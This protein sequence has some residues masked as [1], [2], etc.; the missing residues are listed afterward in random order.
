MGVELQL[1]ATTDVRDE[2]S[3]LLLVVHFLF[4]DVTIRLETGKLLNSVCF[5]CKC[6]SNMSLLENVAENSG[7][8][9]LGQTIPSKQSIYNVVNKLT[10]T[11]SL[12]GKK[13]DRNELC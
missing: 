4:S 13:P 11:G 1:S 9:S 12:L 8:Q 6:I 3:R 5:E 7:C 2:S 10:T